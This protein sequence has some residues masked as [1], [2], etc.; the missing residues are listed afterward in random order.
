MEHV[1]GNTP[2]DPRTVGLN[3]PV[4]LL[5]YTTAQGASEGAKNGSQNIPEN[6]R[7]SGRKLGP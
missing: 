5:L 7:R 3:T 1:R 2:R 4:I 6:Y